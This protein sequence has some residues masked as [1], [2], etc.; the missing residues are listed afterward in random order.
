MMKQLVFAACFFLSSFSMAQW[1]VEPYAGLDLGLIDASCK[2]TGNCSPAGSYT[3]SPN[4]LALGT[5]GGYIFGGSFFA[6]LDLQ[7]TMAGQINVASQPVGAN[8]PNDN[9][10][11]IMMDLQGGWQASDKF[12]LW[13]GLILLNNLVDQGNGGNKTFS[14]DGFRLGGGFL[15]TPNLM[16]SFNYDIQTFKKVDYNGAN[17]DIGND[18]S[19]FNAQ[20]FHFNVSF[21]FTLGDEPRRSSRAKVDEDVDDSDSDA[22]PV[23]AAPK[24]KPL[25]KKKR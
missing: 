6:A 18:Y 14:G 10:Y 19:K 15:I 17:Y 12:K 24:A 20:V 23:K 21:P 8:K 3:Y 1:L 16:I 25:P 9:F 2:G 7:F 22:P 5:R 11:K 13:G 4:G